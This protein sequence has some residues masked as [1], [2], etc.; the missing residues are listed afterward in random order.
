MNKKYMLI[1]R[2][3][4]MQFHTF[5]CLRPFP[6]DMTLWGPVIGIRHYSK[7]RAILVVFLDDFC[8]IFNF[9]MC[10]F[11]DMY[12]LVR[13]YNLVASAKTTTFSFM[14]INLFDFASYIKSW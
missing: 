3:W 14:K 8:E 12:F 2:K 13:K 11:L 9:I 6:E 10:F 5:S 4:F 1:S 7:G